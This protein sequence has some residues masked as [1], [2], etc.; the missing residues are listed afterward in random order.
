MFIYMYNMSHFEFAECSASRLKSLNDIVEE[1]KEI[2]N[3]IQTVH[4]KSCVHTEKQKQPTSC[5]ELMKILHRAKE[6]YKDW[7]EFQQKQ[8]NKCQILQKYM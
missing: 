8:L 5:D 4:D 2:M 1:K 3:K 6:D 7:S